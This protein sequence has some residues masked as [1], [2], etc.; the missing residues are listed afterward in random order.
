MT[1]AT[2]QTADSLARAIRVSEC[3]GG[4]FVV[5]VGAEVY[6]AC[7]SPHEVAYAMATL[8]AER[9][10]GRAAAAAPAGGPPLPAASGS[11]PVP[12]V[13]TRPA[14]APVAL[15]GSRERLRATVNVVG[16]ALLVV[17]SA[18]VGA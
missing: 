2:P 1:Q 16:V 8:L 11:D 17:A 6:A 10:D 3:R 7:V 13:V 14:P 12:A 4:G 18:V 15:A 5:H 9:D